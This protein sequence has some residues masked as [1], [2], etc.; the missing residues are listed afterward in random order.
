MRRFAAAS[1]TLALLGA[2]SGGVVQG[3]HADPPP[4]GLEGLPSGVPQAALDPEP[5]LPTP[6]G[7]PFADAFPRT[8]GTGRVV[9]GAF[10]W[11]DFL[12]DDH[13]AIGVPRSFPIAG[14]APTKGTF[15]YPNATAHK[16]G[17]DIFRVG[18]AADDTASY[19]RVDWTTL[20]N[21]NV[22]IAEFAIDDT[23]NAGAAAW[24]GIANLASP[25]IDRAIVMSAQG[26]WLIDAATGARTALDPPT[27]STNPSAPGSF[28]V[29]V[30]KTLLPT[31]GSWTV[32]VAS[33]L[34]NATGDG[35]VGVDTLGGSLPTEPPAFNVAFRTQAQEPPASN[36]W[37]ENS[38]ATA[39]TAGDVSQFKA[40]L[41]WAALATSRANNTVEPEPLP[42]GYS[43]RWFVSSFKLGDGV[44]ADAQAGT[45]DLAPNYLGQV[46][47]YAVYVPS[48][49]N[50]ASATPLTWVLHSLSEQHNQ[51]G[52]L[53]PN[54][55]QQACEQRHSICATTLGRGPD[56]WYYGAAERDFWEVWN[57]LAMSYRLDPE[58]TVL[59][60][61]SMGGWATY[62]IGLAHPDLFARAVVL[63]GP[64]GCGLR[65]SEQAGGGAGPGAC[66]TDGDSTP[67]IE[68]ARWLPY[69]IGHGTDDEL[70]PV[71][72]VVEQVGQF[73]T[74]GN[75]YR[76]ELYPG[77]DHLAWG[78]SDQFQAGAT[79]MGDGT[80]A[81]TTNPGHV[82]YRWYPNDSAFTT[83]VYWVRDP[84]GRTV[85]PGSTAR[86]DAVSAAR[87]DPAVQ[88]INARGT[89]QNAVIPVGVLEEQTWAVGATPAAGSTI[90]LD[91]KNVASVTIDLAG[92]G[93]GPGVPGTLAITTDGPTAVTL[94]TSAGDVAVP[95]GQTTYSFTG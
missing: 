64:P 4:P 24:P 15:E 58:R 73:R 1:I 5:T 68:N 36:Y 33:G 14:L 47:P 81:R 57:R 75:R 23:P 74:V 55:L 6:A 80:L 40:T 70:V 76:F 12:Y 22:P 94:R 63:A 56:G 84:L 9:S 35:F 31:D 65:F 7:W 72:G 2:L 50:P 51:Y 38:Q 18:V 3:V 92:A 54:F 61:Y 20:A 16:N 88:V 37:M 93:F 85:T 44:I 26:A 42:T 48:S 17:A 49:Y 89:T 69:F 19:W 71:T 90:T 43:N 52:A 95:A 21:A 25:G 66:T 8:S 32:Q 78:A 34:A 87:P 13:G 11:S 39:L 82:T 53:A 27:V 77:M 60:G 79:Y 29:A 41:D 45:G 28:V 46:Q 62:K 67:M 10:E 30:P 83:G 91:L 59:S 86:V